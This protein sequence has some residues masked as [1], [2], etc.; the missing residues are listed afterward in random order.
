[1][2]WRRRWGPVWWARGRGRRFRSL[3]SSW[4]R[5]LCHPHRDLGHRGHACSGPGRGWT[6]PGCPNS[7]AARKEDACGGGDAPAAACRVAR[8]SRRPPRG[9]KRQTH[10]AGCTWG[11]RPRAWPGTKDRTRKDT[12]GTR[13]DKGRRH[14]TKEGQAARRR[15]GAA[16]MATH[17]CASRLAPA[18]WART[19][20]GANGRAGGRVR[21]PRR[22][23]RPDLI[24][25]RERLQCLPQQAHRAERSAQRRGRGRT[26]TH[27][28]QADPP[29]CPR[30][31]GGDRG[32]AA[33][34]A[35]GPRRPAG[36]AAPP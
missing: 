31:V 2:G 29:R 3:G 35:A 36:R 22:G 10:G 11:T 6:T 33:G 13:K 9:P 7:P 28:G 23:G 20:P 34:G 27:A 17:G 12:A 14:G 5:P 1:M 25:W 32:S 24:S 4:R 19:G 21:G 16:R 15:R 26:R 18:R 8:G 30:G